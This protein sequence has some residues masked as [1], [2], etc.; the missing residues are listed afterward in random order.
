MTDIVLATKNNHKIKELN[1][2][3]SP[4]IAGKFVIISMEEA[5]FNGDME[6]SG[7]TFEEN[8]R[9]KAETV[10]RATGL[11]AFADDSGLEVDALNGRPGIYSARYG[12]DDADYD[13]KIRLLLS[14]MENIA[15][16]KRTA[17]FVSVFCCVYPNDGKCVMARGECEGI[18]IREKLG[19]G[20]FGYDPVFYYPPYGKTFAQMTTEEKNTVSHRGRA[21]EKFIKML[22]LDK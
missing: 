21:V 17:R 10:C 22:C 6:E 1:A 2:M 9:I 12:G 18:I 20:N 5:G 4:Y 3:L 8:T 15:D 7:T 16:E 11:I 19:D 13:K 14:E